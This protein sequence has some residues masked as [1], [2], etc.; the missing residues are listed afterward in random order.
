MGQK[1]GAD[2]KESAAGLTIESVGSFLL[3]DWNLDN[4]TQL[5][6]VGDCILAVNG[7]RGDPKQMTKEL[8]SDVLEL[9][10]LGPAGRSV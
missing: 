7:I 4:P 6:K 3:H 2:L 8:D 10:V 5:L 9:F 1:L